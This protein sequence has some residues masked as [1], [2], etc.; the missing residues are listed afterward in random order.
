LT[1]LICKQVCVGEILALDGRGERKK[2]L[3]QHQ[4]Q[5]LF[6]LETEFQG[7]DERVVHLSQDESFCQGVRDFI[8]AD[9]VAL[10]DG[11]ESIDARRITLSD[12]HDLHGMSTMS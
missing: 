6:R 4:I 7:N 12:L 10:S 8:A 3:R 11:L 9:N 5:L 1:N 2:G